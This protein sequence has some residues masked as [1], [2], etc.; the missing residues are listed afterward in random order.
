MRRLKSSLAL[1]LV[2][3]CLW[4]CSKQEPP[5]EIQTVKGGRA[6]ATQWQDETQFVIE[7]TVSDLIGMTYYAKNGVG[8]DSKTFHVEAK[9]I[10]AASAT[11]LTYQLLIRYPDL[12]ETETI[13]PITGPIW[14]PETFRGVADLLIKKVGVNLTTLPSSENSEDTLLQELTNPTPDVIEGQ[15][16]T[17]STELQTHFL[18]PLRHEQAAL[19]LAAFTLREFSGK[20][21]D[22]RAE[23]CRM[24]AH[25]GFAEALRNGASPSLEGK[26]ARV[27][28]C[29]LY[30]DQRLALRLLDEI[31]SGDR[32]TD[33]W[34]RA[35][36]IRITGDYRLS[37]KSPVLTLLEQR[38]T[39]AMRAREIDP[40]LTN[41]DLPKADELRQLTDWSRILN[42]NEPGV[43]IGHEILRRSVRSEIAETTQVYAIYCGT[44]LSQNEFV[45]KLNIEPE[46]CVTVSPSGTTV[47]RV[48][49]WGHWAAFLQRHLCHAIESDFDFLQRRWGVPEQAQKY[50]DFVDEQFG[51]LRLF[52]FVQRQNATE[53]SY[54]RKAQDAEMTV[55]HKCPHL[56]PTTVWN[57]ICDKVPFAALYIPPPHAFVNE[58]HR[59]NPPPGTAYEIVAR[60]RHPSLTGRKD[61]AEIMAQM[62]EMAPYDSDVS[63][64]YLRYQGSPNGHASLTGPA[65]ESGYGP[66]L[67]Y[68]SVL[69]G[70]VAEAYRAQPAKFEEWMKRA[71]E[72]NSCYNYTLAEFYVAAGRD[73]DAA[74]AYEQIV[75]NDPDAVRMSNQ[76]D[77]LVQYYEKTGETE[78]ATQLAESASEVYS[79]EG[80]ATLAHLLERRGDFHGAI[81]CYAKAYERYNDAGSLVACLLRYEKATGK[82]DYA[83]AF[84]EL[85]A[86][87]LP[88]GFE[89][90]EAGKLNG[91]PI[92]GVVILQEDAETQKVGLKLTDIIVG[93]RSY[94]TETFAAYNAIRDMEPDTPF[95]LT[96]WRNN[97]Y[98]EIKASPPKNRFGVQMADYP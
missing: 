97:Q 43:E 44:N 33:A 74:R 28:L 60:I 95:T 45:D 16:N 57:E 79:G 70:A 2:V 42:C 68:D 51:K 36:R 91:P 46:P 92:S 87:V 86:K 72:I 54:Y 9:E 37:T 3:V 58:W 19:L 50:R 10:S 15:N 5:T 93:I 24:T 53:E 30:H 32:P 75:F 66:V 12:S 4:A 17:I 31:P 1:V 78:K 21:F 71:A 65:M 22:I 69:M 77:W 83:P 38:E 40:T 96:V 64:Y 41:R 55:I 34:V 98:I 18:S 56:V 27:A 52:S 84:H 94:R 47:V 61:F 90:I 8:T 25:L 59:P 85:V 49:G 13:L 20:F 48:I 11:P 6:F 35:L 62:H 67:E 14:A 81:E 26:L 23:L 39:F 7:S 80:L 76:C 63:Y 88:H 89:K 82:T 73:A 29:T